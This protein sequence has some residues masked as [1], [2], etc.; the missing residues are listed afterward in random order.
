MPPFHSQGPGMHL[1]PPA[2]RKAKSHHC[3][4]NS[5]FVKQPT[6]YMARRSFLLGLMAWVSPNPA[7][8]SVCWITFEH[9]SCALVFF[10]ACM[11]RA[12]PKTFEFS[13]CSNSAPSLARARADRMSMSMSVLIRG[14]GPPPWPLWRVAAVMGPLQR[15]A[16][17]PGPGPQGLQREHQPQ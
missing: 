8:S 14:A 11:G 5:T 10:E 13:S 2:S 4:R 9:G 16:G 1:P 6:M 12:V 7:M 17:G 15:T 3:N